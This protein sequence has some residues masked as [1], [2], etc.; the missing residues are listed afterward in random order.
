LQ[1]EQGVISM[2]QRALAYLEKDFLSN[3]AMIE[4]INR[5]T[6]E[7]IQADEQGVFLKEATGK[8]Y[9]IST[10]T[11]EK[12]VAWLEQKSDITLIQS[13]DQK[14]SHWLK[15]HKYLNSYMECFQVVYSLKKKIDYSA[16]LQIRKLK[17]EEL[18]IVQKNYDKISK[19]ELREIYN[20]GNLY[21]GI[22]QG[23][24]IGFI[25]N[26]LEGSIGLLEVLKN[27]RKKGFA[28]ELQSYMINHVLEQGG[29]PY[30]QVEIDNLNS[31]NLQ[32]KLGMKIAQKKIYWN[33]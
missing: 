5:N 19:E 13:V 11:F 21:V 1:I 30:A 29:I 7:I 27:Y 4:I 6:A 14:V 16:Q 9:M 32:Q 31:L 20:R 28:T 23:Q 26:H 25:G 10:D 33:F 8:A 22:F 24:I 3:A 17:E 2:K 15:E 18:C 12:A